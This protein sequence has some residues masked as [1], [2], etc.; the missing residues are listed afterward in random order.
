MNCIRLIDSSLFQLVFWGL[1]IFTQPWALAQ[2]FQ[3]ITWGT[4]RPQPYANN[5]GQGEAVNGKWYVFGGFDRLKTC[6]TATDRAYM[7]DP[8][9]NHWTPIANM[10]PMNGTGNGGVT[11]AGF[12][13]DGVN[14]YFAGGYTANRSW[15]GQIFGTREVWQYSIANNTY[16]RL[17]DLPFERAAAQM[18]HV[19][20]K[21]YFIGG[22][23]RERTIDVA[24]HYVLDLNNISNGWQTLAP[25]PNPRQHAGSAVFN[26]K[27]YYF[28]GQKGHDS[29]LIPQDD[30]HVYDPTNNT[31]TQLQDMPIGLNH[32][33][34]SVIV[35]GERILVLGGQT[36]HGLAASAVLAYTPATNTWETLTPLPAARNSG[37]AAY[38]NGAIYYST[39]SSSKTT[40]R[41]LPNIGFN[42]YLEVESNY[43]VIS[44]VGTG[45]IRISGSEL[46]LPNSGD[47]VRVSFNV[48]ITGNYIL[49][50]RLR[51]GN[52]TN[53]TLYWNNG[54][55]FN[56][57]GNNQ[58][59]T[60]ISS[61]IEPSTS[62]GGSFFSLMESSVL[63]LNEGA[64]FVEIQ[65]NRSNC[66]IDYLNVAYQNPPA[67]LQALTENDADYV[68]YATH[69]TSYTIEERM[70]N[71]LCGDHSEKP[72]VLSVFP[73][74]M[75]REKISVDFSREIIGDLNYSLTDA[76]GR[77][78]IKGKMNMNYATEL[79]IK[80]NELKISKGVYF[81]K[82]KAENLS[83]QIIRLMKD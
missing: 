70:D 21:L 35:V 38:L 20:G 39:G 27:I 46:L 5:E 47:R 18:K 78:I 42:A 23:N 14:I 61:S 15:T 43:T 65:A 26:G 44:D 13:N 69:S 60:G 17:P 28:G 54:Y 2:N 59:F 57:N 73:N 11:H 55:I 83:P 12:T 49:R 81:L 22:T 58:T 68:A 33:S 80:I 51:S 74:P 45:A 67:M 3:T 24:D 77:E 8:N 40:Y 41:G 36:R 4:V 1:T 34:S 37:M 29:R 66:A 71:D 75:N 9:T 63:N 82:L 7:Y 52:A 72:R 30:V 53:Q 25:L 56:V 79:D 32:T 6:C 50:F 10:P 48:P 19:N 64:N 16:I 62:Y 31:W 76:N